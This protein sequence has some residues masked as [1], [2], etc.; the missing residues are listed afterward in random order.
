MST[1]TISF[2]V[3]ERKTIKKLTE[4]FSSKKEAFAYLKKHP[5]AS[6]WAWE[7]VMYRKDMTAEEI[8]DLINQSRFKVL[9]QWVFKIPTVEIYIKNLEIS[10]ID[11]L[12]KKI[13]SFEFQ[14]LAYRIK[15]KFISQRF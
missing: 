9:W 10:S 7:T 1:E 12:S 5:N 11:E 6:R 13:N 3:L 2:I 14:R 4:E 15:G 8:I